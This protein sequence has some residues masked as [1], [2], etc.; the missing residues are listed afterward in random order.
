MK[1]KLETVIDGIAK[2]IDREIY[3]GMNDIQELMAR[4]V[5]GRMIDN[6][7]A[8]K[9][10]LVSNGIIRT[11]GIIDSEGMVDVDSLTRDVKKEI[12]RKGKLVI[13]LPMFGK[14]TFMPEDVD[15]IYRCIKGDTY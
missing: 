11:F 7:E 12:E 13:T 2:Y 6:T 10:A 1:Y 9:E 5:V 4:V 8:I 15:A 3:T 14:M